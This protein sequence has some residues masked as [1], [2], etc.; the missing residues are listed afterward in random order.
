M[1]WMGMGKVFEFIIPTGNLHGVVYAYG[2]CVIVILMYKV[3]AAS[4]P[5]QPIR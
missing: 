1:G 3:Q 4:L 2:M 5:G